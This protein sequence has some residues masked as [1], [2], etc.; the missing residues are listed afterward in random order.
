M[1]DNFI[2]KMKHDLLLVDLSMTIEVILKF[3]C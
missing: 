2:A 1:T 3:Y